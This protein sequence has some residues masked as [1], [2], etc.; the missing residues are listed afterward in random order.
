MH[1][2][3]P[4]AVMELIAKYPDVWE[5]YEKLGETTHE[6]GPLDEKTRKLVKLGIAIGARLEG[7]VS[8]H[9]KR[10][11]EAGIT[12]EELLH[13]ALLAITTIGFPGAVAGMTWIKRMTGQ[14]G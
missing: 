3:L 14:E 11:L 4:K 8:S 2:A 5:A 12:E 6:A 1:G 13:V 7:A 10:A 9:T